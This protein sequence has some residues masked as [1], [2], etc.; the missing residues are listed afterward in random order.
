MRSIPRFS[1]VIQT[2]QSCAIMQ[3]AFSETRLGQGFNSA[4]VF[5]NFVD[6]KLYVHLSCPPVTLCAGTFAMLWHD[7]PKLWL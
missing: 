4:T 7:V 3:L 2:V 5:S 1:V 6:F